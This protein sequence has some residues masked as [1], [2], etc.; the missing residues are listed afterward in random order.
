VTQKASNSMHSDK[1]YQCRMKWKASCCFHAR[2][3]GKEDDT[4]TWK[5]VTPR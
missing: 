4:V 1:Q 3:L 2:L 5:A